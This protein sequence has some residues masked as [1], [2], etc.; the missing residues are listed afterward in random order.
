MLASTG[1]IKTGTVLELPAILNTS[2]AWI[3][4]V[5]SGLLLAAFSAR[6]RIYFTS[7]NRREYEQR[8]AARQVLSPLRH[9]SAILA[10]LTPHHQGSTVSQSFDAK[11]LQRVLFECGCAQEV[12]PEF[13]ACWENDTQSDQLRSTLN[14]VE[15]C[16]T[17]AMLYVE[18]FV[19]HGPSEQSGERIENGN[20]VE[21]WQL[22]VSAVQEL[23]QQIPAL[24][25]VISELS[26]EL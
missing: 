16:T 10:K 26:T 12:L 9:I 25:A 17:T 1:E 14:E 21:A 8:R 2:F 13:I 22:S 15:E 7:K 3:I 24:K 18:R 11:V 20:H 23:T 4:G 19:S 5:A 6:I